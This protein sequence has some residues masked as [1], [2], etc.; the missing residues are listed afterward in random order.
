MGETS[1]KTIPIDELVNN[2]L[3]DLAINSK[4]EVINQI[5]ISN[6]NLANIHR[7]ISN[8]KSKLL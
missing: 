3:L 5:P 6:L 8:I 2:S 7:K 1:V 4:S